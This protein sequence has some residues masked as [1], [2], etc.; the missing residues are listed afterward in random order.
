MVNEKGPLRSPSLPNKLNI[1]LKKRSDLFLQ[2]RNPVV[3]LGFAA[4]CCHLI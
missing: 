1:F 2:L 3:G 4:G